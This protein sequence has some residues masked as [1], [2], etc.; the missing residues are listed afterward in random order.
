[1]RCIG[2]AHSTRAVI[3]A[4]AI[5]KSAAAAGTMMLMD[6]VLLLGW[7]AKEPDERRR[8]G[9]SWVGVGVGVVVVGTRKEQLERRGTERH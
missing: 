8:R 7:A 5:D 6:G 4:N 2:A 3:L 9:L 1:M